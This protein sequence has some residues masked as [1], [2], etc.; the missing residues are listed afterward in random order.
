MG[1]RAGFVAFCCWAFSLG[2]G[3]ALGSGPALCCA[4]GL[5]GRSVPGLLRL[6][7]AA[8]LGTVDLRLSGRGELPARHAVA[9]HGDS[10]WCDLSEA[11]ARLLG[12]RATRFCGL[13]VHLGRPCDADASRDA[14]CS[15]HSCD[16]EPEPA[17]E[18][19]TCARCGRARADTCAHCDGAGACTSAER[20]DGRRSA[21][22]EALEQRERERD[23]DER[24]APQRRSVPLLQ[25]GEPR[26]VRALGQVVA[27]ASAFLPA[28]PAVDGL[29]HG[30]LCLG[31][32]Q[33]VLELFSE[34]SSRAEEERL[35]RGGRH[36]ENLGDL[37][38]RPAL[39]LAQDDRLP[40]LWRNLGQRSEELADAGCL[41]VVLVGSGMGD[42]I[43][44]LD[45][46]RPR[47]LLPKALL[48]RVARD[49]EQPIGGLRGRTPCSRDLYA[50]RN[51]VCVTSSASAWFPSTANAYR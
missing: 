27:Q 34:R 48:D 9:G 35:E 20:E 16:L 15:H 41:V 37:A 30:E 33:L 24:K 5:A 18:D 22:F 43:V 19:T 12:G 11:R 49:R 47:L 6:G 38:V 3:L 42:P 10:P 45:L 1:A 36:T 40:L 8:L 39:E 32:R 14:S 7:A 51:V 50:F 25:T 29:R 4:D 21:P 2:G 44:E 26:A 17:G 46:A 23:R 28:E 31:A 13:L